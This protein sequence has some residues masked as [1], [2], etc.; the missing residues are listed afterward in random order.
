MIN[1]TAKELFE[2]YSKDCAF[3]SVSDKGEILKSKQLKAS[4][5]AVDK[6]GSIVIMWHDDIDYV[7]H[8]AFLNKVHS[9]GTN[10]IDG[11]FNN[12]DIASTIAKDYFMKLK[13]KRI[14]TLEA[15]INRIKAEH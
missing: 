3:M 13:Q 4:F 12:K 5:V 1:L 2:K 11:V 14:A 15:E 10:I 8:H 9:A 7:L 6:D